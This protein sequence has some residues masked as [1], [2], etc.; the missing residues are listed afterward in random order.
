MTKICKR[1]NQEK[2]LDQFTK[3]A[4]NKDGH[5]NECKPCKVEYVREH[6]R[7]VLGR[8]SYI[9]LGQ[10]RSSKDRGH[11]PPAYSKKDLLNWVK[12]NG[13][14]ALMNS[15]ILSEYSKDLAPSVDRLNPDLPYSL[16]NIRLVP[17]RDNNDK[18]YEDRKSCRHITRQNRKV[19]QR[20]MDGSVV[21]EYGSIANAARSTGIT[22]INI[23]DVCRKKKHCLTAGGF[24]WEYID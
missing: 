5:I 13:I 14:E 19:R 15:W 1:C 22:R 8:I 16:R 7:T 10:L 9:Y 11:P 6:Y 24:L 3:S 20:N 2:P 17:W 12:T 4:Q 18:A 21:A 23:N